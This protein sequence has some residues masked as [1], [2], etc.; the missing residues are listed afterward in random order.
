VERLRKISAF[1]CLGNLSYEPGDMLGGGE[2]IHAFRSE[3]ELASEFAEGG[4]AL[5]HLHIPQEKGDFHG[6]ALL[7]KTP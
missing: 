3:G 7:Q 5:A 6:I 2:F 1:L 4:F